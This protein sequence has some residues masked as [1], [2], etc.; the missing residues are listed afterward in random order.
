MRHIVILAT[1][2]FL[3]AAAGHSFAAP[4]S[5]AELARAEGGANVILVQDKPKEGESLTKKVKRVWRNIVGYHFDVSCPL[6]GQS[7]CADTGKDR[8]EAQAKCISRNPL[9]W[10]SEKK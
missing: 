5:P 7:T 9:C 6:R 2:T 8:G 3:I 1:S 4:I 10:V